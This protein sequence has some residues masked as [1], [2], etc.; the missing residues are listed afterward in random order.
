LA[1]GEPGAINAAYLAIEIMALQ[2]DELRVKLAEDRISKS[3]KVE[4]DS[5]K[6]EVIL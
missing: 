2:D 6:I 5:S 1:I 4:L 3:K